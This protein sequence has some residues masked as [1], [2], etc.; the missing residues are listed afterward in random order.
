MSGGLVPGLNPRWEQWHHP[1]VRSLQGKRTDDPKCRH[2]W[3]QAYLWIF[4][5]GW[6]LP[7]LFRRL[8]AGMIGRVGRTNK[9]QTWKAEGLWRLFKR[10][11]VAQV[12]TEIKCKIGGEE[13]KHSLWKNILLLLELCHSRFNLFN[14]KF[15]LSSIFGLILEFVCLS[16]CQWEWLAT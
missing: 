15:V 2:L 10:T 6:N 9:T 7:A 3:N 13:G 16:F 1:G 8:R 4:T 5:L 14:K 11:G 12:E